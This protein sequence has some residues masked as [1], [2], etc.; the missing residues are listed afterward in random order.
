LIVWRSQDREFKRYLDYLFIVVA[1]GVLVSAI[2]AFTNLGDDGKIVDTLPFE[3]LPTTIAVPTTVALAT[4]TATTQAEPSTST[5]AS[6]SSSTSTA[7]PTTTTRP[8]VTTVATVPATSPTNPPPTTPADRT[9]PSIGPFRSSP[10]KLYE[11]TSNPKL[12]VVISDASGVASAK[13][14]QSSM[15]RDP[16]TNV[17]FLRGAPPGVVPS[18]QNSITIPVPISAKDNKGNSST[19]TDDV[20]IYDCA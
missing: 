16:G 8:A 11:C 10:S 14:F 2:Y 20:T 5:A 7:A 13:M 17:W 1:V 19:V 3:P 6:T 18:G 4:T 12:Y 15:S 9:G